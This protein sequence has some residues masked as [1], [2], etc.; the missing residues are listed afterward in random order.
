[1]TLIYLFFR[2]LKGILKEKQFKER[3]SLEV[4]LI[5]IRQYTDPNIPTHASCGAASNGA[6]K[7]E[8]L[9]QKMLQAGESHV[10]IEPEKCASA[11]FRIILE[12]FR[13]N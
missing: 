8:D 4:F 6:S 7:F 13:R 9:Q 3:K 10:T 5:N 2:V 1:M 12:I 11:A